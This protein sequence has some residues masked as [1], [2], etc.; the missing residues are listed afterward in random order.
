[1][2]NMNIAVE[3]LRGAQRD[4]F[5]PAILVSGDSDVTKPMLAVQA[6]YSGTRVVVALPPDR[7]PSQLQNSATAGFMIGPKKLLEVA[8]ALEAVKLNTNQAQPMTASAWMCGR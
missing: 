6:C 4:A 2:T 3:Q 5:V 8:V 1:M 7:E